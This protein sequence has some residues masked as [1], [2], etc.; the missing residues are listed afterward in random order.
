MNEMV[1]EPDENED[2]HMKVLKS[3]TAQLM[4]HF[5]NVQIF[6]TRQNND[7]DTTITAH[8]GG[9]NWYARYGHVREWVTREEERARA[10]VRIDE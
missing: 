3:H 9:G 2:R 7:D 5:D 1:E 10:N 4:E 6:A 8:F